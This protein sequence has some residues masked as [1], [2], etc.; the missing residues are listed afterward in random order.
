M[1]QQVKK[2]RILG[3]HPWWVLGGILLVA[4]VVFVIV[5]NRLNW[6]WTGFTGS[7]LWDWMSL[8]FLP[9][10]LMVATVWFN[11]RKNQQANASQG[12]QDITPSQK[13]ALLTLI[14]TELL[15]AKPPGYTT[16]PPPT[17]L[18]SQPRAGG[19][20]GSVSLDARF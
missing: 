4:F 16:V 10:A 9:V 1:N 7:K 8:L 17:T 20:S 11:T 3:L 18:A 19:H 5:A 6:Q 2:T 14:P 15:P 12:V 13:R